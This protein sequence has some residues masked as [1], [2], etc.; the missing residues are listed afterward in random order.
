MSAIARRDVSPHRVCVA[1]NEAA[2]TAHGVLRPDDDATRFPPARSNSDAATQAPKASFQIVLYDLFI[3]IPSHVCHEI[4]K[5]T[6]SATGSG[7]TGLSKVIRACFVASM[8]FDKNGLKM[9][10]RKQ[11]AT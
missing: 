3:F 7:G 8:P 4:Q 1:T 10:I 5:R 9:Q 2:A 6:E 11:T